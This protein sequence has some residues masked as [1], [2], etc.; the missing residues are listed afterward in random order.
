MAVCVR[1]S[2]FYLLFISGNVIG[3]NTVIGEI[4]T[5]TTIE[6]W[7]SVSKCAT[8]RHHVQLMNAAVRFGLP[9]NISGEGAWMGSV[10]QSNNKHSYNS[11]NNNNNNN[12]SNKYPFL[13]SK[14]ADLPE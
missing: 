6:R 7:L 4:F 1:A 5:H 13:S 14:S 2:V 9:G 11:S 8:A 3:A 12:N 10:S